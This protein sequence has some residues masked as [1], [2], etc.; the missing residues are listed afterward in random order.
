M[1]VKLEHASDEALKVRG[2][3]VITLASRLGMGIPEFVGLVIGQKLV[4][5]IIH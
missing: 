1:R 5:A 2:I 3:V 4:V